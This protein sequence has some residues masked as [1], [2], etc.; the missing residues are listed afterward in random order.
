MAL[1][2]CLSSVSARAEDIV[3]CVGR[4]LLPAGEG[5]AVQKKLQA[6]YQGVSSLTAE[7][8]QHSFL[9]AL[10]VA[11]SSSGLVS[12]QRP[13]KMAWDYQEPEVQQFIFADSTMWF[14]Q[15]EQNQVLI[16]SAKDVLLSD[17]PISFLLGIGDISRDFNLVGACRRE[18]GIVLELTPKV[19]GDEQSGKGLKGFQLLVEP[20]RSLPIGARVVDLGGNVTTVLLRNV[21]T[22]ASLD[23]KRFTPSFPSGTDIQDR[24]SGEENVL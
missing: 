17:L 12:F 11:E 10:E 5:A 22:N 20:E 13:G 4:K 21:T 24:R 14:Y 15:K 8:L 7:F 2:L 18:E 19:A 23:Q 16:D 3:T 6:A 9:Q 1:G